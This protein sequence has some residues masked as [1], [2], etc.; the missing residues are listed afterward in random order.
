MIAKPK[1]NIF[2]EIGIPFNILVVNVLTNKKIIITMKNNTK[3]QVREIYIH[4]TTHDQ[5]TALLNYLTPI[6]DRIDGVK[7]VSTDST[8]AGYVLL[9]YN[10]GY[11]TEVNRRRCCFHGFPRD[12]FTDVFQELKIKHVHFT[13][14]NGT[15]LAMLFEECFD[16]VTE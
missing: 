8:N 4:Y 2:R 10:S 1:T 15:R 3:K 6:I 12:H 5:R 14:N 9:Q 16:I 11:A 7:Q 13:H